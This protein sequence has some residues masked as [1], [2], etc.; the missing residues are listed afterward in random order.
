MGAT[1]LA[2]RWRRTDIGGGRKPNLLLSRENEPANGMAVRSAACDGAR[3]GIARTGPPT[4]RA[5]MIVPAAKRSSQFQG[6]LKHVGSL[7][8]DVKLTG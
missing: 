3:L 8:P 2:R 1:S 5:D 4:L 6:K 7:S